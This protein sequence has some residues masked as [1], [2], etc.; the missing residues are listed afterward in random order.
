M[1]SKYFQV[2]QGFQ[3]SRIPQ[4]QGAVG[5]KVPSDGIV[6]GVPTSKKNMDTYDTYVFNINPPEIG[7]LFH[8][9]VSLCAGMTPPFIP[10]GFG[11]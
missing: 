9:G 8:H 7:F 11:G 4:L 2:F 10:S 3:G 1:H 6:A 5:C